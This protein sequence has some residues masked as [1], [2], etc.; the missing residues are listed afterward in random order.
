MAAIEGSAINVSETSVTIVTIEELITFEI[1]TV[2]KV[3]Q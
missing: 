2:T 1:Q 3:D